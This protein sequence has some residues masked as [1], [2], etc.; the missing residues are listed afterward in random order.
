MNPAH[1]TPSPR[2][3]LVLPEYLQERL[4]RLQQGEA[5]GGRPPI[6]EMAGPGEEAKGLHADPVL[7]P[8]LLIWSHGSPLCTAG[9]DGVSSLLAE[10]DSQV[11]V[12]DLGLSQT[13]SLCTSLTRTFWASMLT[14]GMS[15]VAENTDGTCIFTLT[16]QNWI[17]G[18]NQ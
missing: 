14:A 18:L 10:G 4:L 12:S 6:Q 5:F 17:L 13:H 1:Q 9:H 8:V 16:L 3:A 2:K 15:R 11:G 7:F